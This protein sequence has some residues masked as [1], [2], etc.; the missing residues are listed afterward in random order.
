MYLGNLIFGWNQFGASQQF[1][2]AKNKTQGQELQKN[3]IMLCSNHL[4]IP[5]CST[6]KK[7]KHLH[8][9]GTLYIRMVETGGS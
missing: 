5:I 7:Q 6:I 8:Y 4:H 9:L 1:S 3:D 2:A